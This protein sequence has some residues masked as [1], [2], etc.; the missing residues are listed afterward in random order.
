MGTYSVQKIRFRMKFQIS[1]IL[2]LM[3]TKPSGSRQSPSSYRHDL[4]KE[5]AATKSGTNP[6]KHFRMHWKTKT[7][8]G[9]FIQERVLFMV[10]KLNSHCRIVSAE[11]G[12]AEL[13]RLI[14]QC[15]NVLM[16][17]SSARTGHVTHRSCSTEPFLAA[18]NA[19]SAS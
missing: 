8:N 14:S 18:L 16:Q 7:W 17:A 15:L 9:S 3:S 10:R 5:L 2:F 1:L 13:F 6:K 12:N 4:T 11:S 19:S